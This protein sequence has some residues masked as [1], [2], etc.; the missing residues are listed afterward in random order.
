MKKLLVVT[1]AML[2]VLAM[3]IPSMAGLKITGSFE[4]SATYDGYSSVRSVSSNMFD[5]STLYATFTFED[6]NA[7][8]K[9]PVKF[10]TQLSYTVEYIDEPYRDTNNNNSYDAGVDPFKDIN[11]NG[12]RDKAYQ[13]TT[14][15]DLIQFTSNMQ[16]MVQ[17]TIIHSG[18][19][20]PI[21]WA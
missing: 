2:T 5:N 1:I 14:N 21:R 10:G 6:A 19:R 17:I 4:S 8:V 20:Q 15:G 3:A 11:G 16:P 13:L 9:V 18:Q 12:V 7:L